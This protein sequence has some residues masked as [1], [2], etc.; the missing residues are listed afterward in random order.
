MPE[1]VILTP[2]NF[3]EIIEK[4]VYEGA[5]L[6]LNEIKKNEAISVNQLVKEKNLG[7]YKKIKK[8][9]STG[10]LKTL[11]DGKVSRQE[12]ENYLKIK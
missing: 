6:A 10:L 9:I 3:R 5:S 7:G 2:E 1:I 12:I 4:A 8:L 11:P